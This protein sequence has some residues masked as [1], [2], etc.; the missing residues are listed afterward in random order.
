MTNT[1]TSE[2]CTS[3]NNEISLIT[4]SFESFLRDS[5]KEGLAILQKAINDFTFDDTMKD[6]CQTLLAV[7]AQANNSHDLYRFNVHSMCQEILNATIFNPEFGS[8]YAAFSQLQ[9]SYGAV[10]SIVFYIYGI[11]ELSQKESNSQYKYP[12]EPDNLFN[13]AI[14]L[15]ENKAVRNLFYFARAYGRINEPAFHK[16]ALSIQTDVDSISKQFAEDSSTLTGIKNNIEFYKKMYHSQ[17]KQEIDNEYVKKINALAIGAQSYEFNSAE[18]L[19]NGMADF[20]ENYSDEVNHDYFFNTTLLYL[21]ANTNDDYIKTLIREKHLNYINLMNHLFERTLKASNNVTATMIGF[22]N[23]IIHEDVKVNLLKVNALM[24]RIRSLNSSNRNRYDSKLVDYLYST[25]SA[26]LDVAISRLDKKKDRRFINKES[27]EEKAKKAEA[28]KIQQEEEAKAKQQEKEEKERRKQEQKAVERAKKKAQEEQNH[29]RKDILKQEKAREQEE[30]KRAKINVPNAQVVE[31]APNTAV[32]EQNEKE[33]A[34]KKEQE[35]LEKE[36]IEKA[37]QLLRDKLAAE[38][39]Q[40]EQAAKMARDKEENE[41]KEKEEAVKKQKETTL[42]SKIE[43][44]KSNS[45]QD[46]ESQVSTKKKRKKAKNNTITINLKQNQAV[47]EAVATTTT[48][49]NKVKIESKP[50]TPSEKQA[51]KQKKKAEEAEKNRQEAEEAARKIK[52]AEEAERKIKE[53]EEAERKKIEAKE[54]LEENESTTKKSDDSILLN[55]AKLLSSVFTVDELNKLNQINQALLAKFGVQIIFKGS[56]VTKWNMINHAVNKAEHY[57]FSDVDMYI[58]APS[59]ADMQIMQAQFKEIVQLLVSS[60]FTV[61]VDV[62]PFKQIKHLNNK[63][64]ENDKL[65]PDTIGMINENGHSIVYWMTESGKLIQKSLPYLAVSDILLLMPDK[66]QTTTDLNL[67]KKVIAKYDVFNRYEYNSIPFLNLEMPLASGLTCDL[68]NRK[69]DY[70]THQ[71]LAINSGEMVLVCQ[72]GN[73]DFIAHKDNA[74]FDRDC[75]ADR[76]QVEKPN[77]KYTSYAWCL[78]KT[79]K[80]FQGIKKIEGLDDILNKG[81]LKEVYLQDFRNPLPKKAPYLEFYDFI[82]NQDKAFL[83]QD[84]QTDRASLDYINPIDF[85]RPAFQA[86]VSFYIETHPNVRINPDFENKLVEVVINL[87]QACYIK[88]NNI[89]SASKSVLANQLNAI[90]EFC[91]L[92][93]HSNASVFDKLYQL[94]D[95]VS[96]VDAPKLSRKAQAPNATATPRKTNANK[97][98]PVSRSHATFGMFQQ[99]HK[100]VTQPPVSTTHLPPSTTYSQAPSLGPM[101]HHHLAY[102]PVYTQT[103]GYAMPASPQQMGAYLYPASPNPSGYGYVPP[104]QQRAP[105]SSSN[106]YPG[107]PLAYAPNYYQGVPPQPQSPAQNGFFGYPSSQAVSMPPQPT[108]A[109]P[110][111]AQVTALQGN[112]NGFAANK[113]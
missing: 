42:V 99:T 24:E 11:C 57:P 112:G 94:R 84:V 70:V 80:K 48:E 4:L 109:M 71:P 2:T 92:T 50:L 101:P 45:E 13:D 8:K 21:T 40:K 43:D 85:I 59:H 53:A 75:V 68:T 3:E 86:M 96:A 18:Q 63:L 108:A 95:G 46:F 100:A 113:S 111:H 20:L 47:Q 82:K 38:K 102:Q 76:I 5:K 62:Q 33:A 74:A 90:I 77:A 97:N 39:L 37:G 1:R 44:N 34:E 35:R 32:Q 54:A 52:E 79:A 36:Q 41:R 87:T 103:Q 25:M 105:I 104:K 9:D 60:G 93:H 66:S 51:L 83:K 12:F 19:S 22:Y 27:E 89:F 110:T 49:D 6:K 65:P 29:I 31:E 16:K 107:H 26:I 15:C 10:L 61:N 72:N 17:K 55:K 58:Q 69:P 78:Y 91:L 23:N 28:L 73:F 98:N 64:S 106:Y 56:F 14:C 88:D 67:L 7:F 81:L 30:K